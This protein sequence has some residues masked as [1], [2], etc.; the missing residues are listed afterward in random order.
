MVVLYLW[1]LLIY[2]RSIITI[3]VIDQIRRSIAT[4]PEIKANS[5]RELRAHLVWTAIYFTHGSSKSEARR[6]SRNQNNSNNIDEIWKKGTMGKILKQGITR[7]EALTIKLPVNHKEQIWM[8]I[9]Y[10]LDR[11][12]F[13]YLKHSLGTRRCMVL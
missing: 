12:R 7:A 10:T 6:I 8:I 4:V 5:L 13:V 1:N 3:F 9:V 11:K 2:T